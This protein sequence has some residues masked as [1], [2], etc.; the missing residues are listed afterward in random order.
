LGSAPQRAEAA[1]RKAD[2]LFRSV[3]HSATI[4]IAV[5]DKTQRIITTNRALQTMMGYTEDERPR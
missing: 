5:L 2:A 1:F 3:F 4:G